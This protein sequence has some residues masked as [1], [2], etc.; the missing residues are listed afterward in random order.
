MGLADFADSKFQRMA[1][2]PSFDFFIETV[3]CTKQA[4]FYINYIASFVFF[5]ESQL[6]IRWNSSLQN[7]PIP[8]DSSRKITSSSLIEQ[9]TFI[10]VPERKSLPKG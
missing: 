10:N 8:I 7:R 2:W 5:I 1:N 4:V 6:A 9:E 3:N